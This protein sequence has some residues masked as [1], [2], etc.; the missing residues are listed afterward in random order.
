MKQPS[1]ERKNASLGSGRAWLG[2]ILLV[3]GCLAGTVSAGVGPGREVDAVL[4]QS[5]AILGDSS[6]GEKA[7]LE[8]LRAVVL[9]VFD[10][11]E[12]ARR[13]L[14]SHWRRRTPEHREEF[15]S[16]FTRLL[17]RTYTS[18]ISAYNGQR[19]KVVGEEIDDRFARVKTEITDRDGRR[20]KV[21]YRM[22]RVGEPAK[23]R[24]YDVV[25]EDISLVNNYRAQFNR[26]INRKS[27]ENLLERLRGQAG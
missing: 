20:F 1:R 3:A 21:D 8:R 24:I 4:R 17:E 6:L 11:P 27:F 10:F 22:H 14:G 13:S 26:V 25:I 5:V 18:R 7:K 12:M 16:L 2:A 15:T 19:T 23:W 9:P